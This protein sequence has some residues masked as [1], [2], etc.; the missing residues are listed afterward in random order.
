V[1]WVLDN[2]DG[3]SL[4]VLKDD[5]RDDVAQVI[6]LTDVLDCVPGPGIRIVGGMSV[7]VTIAFNKCLLYLRGIRMSG[8]YGDQTDERRDKGNPHLRSRSSIPPSGDSFEFYEN[9]NLRY[10]RPAG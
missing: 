4:D 10:T 2:A 1:D 7:G 9:N 6:P 3:V 5:E 8:M